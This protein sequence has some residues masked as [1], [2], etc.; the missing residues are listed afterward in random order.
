[1]DLGGLLISKIKNS[2]KI[3]I[4]KKFIFE[5]PYY[6]FDFLFITV[7]L[8]KNIFQYQKIYKKNL[9]IVTASDKFFANSLFQLLENLKLQDEIDEIIV[10][11]L[12]MTPEQVNK[13]YS[14]YTDV[15]YKR[16]V[17][18]DYPKFNM[19]LISNA[20]KPFGFTVMEQGNNKICLEKTQS[21]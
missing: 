13:L 8:L 14:K 18:D 2:T 1:M 10:Y 21:I 17:F 20:I 19:Q 4:L 6:L 16:F 7:S 15:T 5:S 12:G 3:K 11:D 9:V